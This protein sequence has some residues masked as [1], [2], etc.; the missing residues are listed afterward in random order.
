[1]DTFVSD[2]EGYLKIIEREIIPEL[3]IVY[4]DIFDRIWWLEDGDDIERSRRPD[5]TPSSTDLND[6]RTRI[7]T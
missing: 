4:G 6:L 3:Q 1:M 7:T 2:Y 5:L